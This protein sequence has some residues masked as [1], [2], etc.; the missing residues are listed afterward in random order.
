MNPADRLRE[1]M[2]AGTDD[3]TR[4]IPEN[5]A[6]ALSAVVAA[7]DR[8]PAAAASPT[9]DL[10]S[11][12][13][14]V[15]PGANRALALCLDQAASA[16]PV[17]PALPSADDWANRLLDV[18]AALDA[19]GQVLDHAAT[20]FMQM[21][22]AES[23]RIDAWIT[24]RHSPVSWRERADFD[25]WARWS[26]AA[27]A[28][29]AT[30]RRRRSASQTT[31]M[32]DVTG[33]TSTGSTANRAAAM[34]DRMAYQ[35]GYPADAALA[36][37]PV[38]VALGVLRGLIA[39]VLDAAD[40]RP[41][42]L[43]EAALIGD[44]TATLSAGPEVI[45]RALAGFTLDA[46][47]A[48]W[49]AAVPG[50]APAPLVR[51]DPEHLLLSRAGLTSEPLLFL[52]RELRRRD[53]TAVTTS[54]HLR[55]A[56]FRHDLY[57]LFSDRR[58][59]SSTGSI[60]LRRGGGDL[61]TD[62]DAAIFDRKT[63]A[64]GLFELKSQEP[65]ARSLAERT[66]QRDNLR[67]AGRQVAGILDWINHHGADEILNRID[68]ETA[69]R[70]RVQKVFPFV[71]G[72]YLAHVGDGAARDHRAAWGT[73]PQVLRLRDGQPVGPNEPRPLATLHTRL[74][75]DATTITIPPDAPPQTIR[76]STISLTVYPSLA[77]RRATTPSHDG[78][79]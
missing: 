47:G 78:G 52:T 8:Q 10:V 44:L 56:A 7:I 46:A 48:A 54:A 13:R 23:G 22:G 36:G 45:A 68:R 18:C 75:Q 24:T 67:Y 28:P 4:L 25:W 64:L 55:E 39:R 16:D 65:F 73:W 9:V 27:S 49:H 76:I 38:A 21:A 14:L 71:L 35:F 69:K 41:V 66:R 58:F 6:A 19:A 11:G 59:V 74:T 3:S 72:R 29:N 5:R 15:H 2:A 20:G 61:R 33:M 60:R 77:A 1:A 62:I 50:I 12:H 31:P 26:R 42:L 43:T 40:D 53:A 57:D 63:G 30:D 51:R 79:H 34:A 32:P 17:P 37:I 70:F